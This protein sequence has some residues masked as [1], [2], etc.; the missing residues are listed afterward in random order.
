MSD[1]YHIAIEVSWEP[2]GSL[3][4]YTAVRQMLDFTVGQIKASMVQ[5]T[6]PS[7]SLSVYDGADKAQFN[8]DVAELL[9]IFIEGGYVEDEE[10]SRLIERIYSHLTSGGS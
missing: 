4:E 5:V 1:R 2:S 7:V 3:G 9:D 6:D 8:T 10:D